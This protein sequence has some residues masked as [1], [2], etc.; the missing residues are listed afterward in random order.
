MGSL[1]ALPLQGCFDPILLNSTDVNTNLRP[2][3]AAGVNSTDVKTSFGPQ[4]AA[5]VNSTDANASFR[6]PTPTFGK[7]PPPRLG[8]P[9]PA[10]DMK[11]FVPRGN[12]AST[13][14][15]ENSVIL[16]RISDW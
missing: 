2:P 8:Q 9:K 11:L 16:H 1:I 3:L 10:K 5:G 13:S 4:L 14:G 7:P 6:P 12:Y 15:H